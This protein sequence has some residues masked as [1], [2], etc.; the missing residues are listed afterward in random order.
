[1]LRLSANVTSICERSL[2][3]FA[4][5]IYV[6]ISVNNFLNIITEISAVNALK[7]KIARSDVF[8]E[9]VIEISRRIILATQ[10]IFDFT[11]KLLK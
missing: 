1:M 3:Y 5:G 10:E 2:C 7:N 4:R 11:P 6:T 8:R 9:A